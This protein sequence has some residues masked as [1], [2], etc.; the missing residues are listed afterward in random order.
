L[1][2]S[3]FLSQYNYLTINITYIN[4][5]KRPRDSV[6]CT[7]KLQPPCRHDGATCVPHA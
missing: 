6:H 5:H 1:N 7:L 4:V 2:I 3:F